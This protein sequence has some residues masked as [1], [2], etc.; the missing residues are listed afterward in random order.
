MSRNPIYAAGLLLIP[1]ASALLSNSLY[2][3]F[4]HSISALYLFHVVSVEEPF[5][6]KID[7]VAYS[8]YSSAT[9]RFF[10]APLLYALLLLL[11]IHL[12]EFA[13]KLPELRRRSDLGSLPYHFVMTS[14]WGFVW[15]HKFPPAPSSTKKKA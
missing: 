13:Y 12:L 5:L 3:L 6:A 14:L 15:W 4:A 7:H 1:A 8:A 2:P 10:P 9:P 11:S